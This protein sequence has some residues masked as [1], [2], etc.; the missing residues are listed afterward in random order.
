MSSPIKLTAVSVVQPTRM[1]SKLDNTTWHGMCSPGMGQG[2]SVAVV[3]RSREVGCLQVEERHM[4]TMGREKVDKYKD[5][6]KRK[7][8]TKKEMEGSALSVA[9]KKA[10][11]PPVVA[12]KA[13]PI[14]SPPAASRHA[15]RSL[16]GLNVTET[17]H[18]TYSPAELL[19][20]SCSS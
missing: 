9:E 6:R 19:F 7:K 10:L 12:W 16:V 17:S 11:R 15:F 8:I 20:R 3:M 4:S 18:R 1:L 5:G 14:M 13:A 2:C